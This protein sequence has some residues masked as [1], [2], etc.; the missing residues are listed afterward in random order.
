MNVDQDLATCYH[1][2]AHAVFAIQVSG[3]E[4]RYVDADEL[5]CAA[6]LRGFD[7]YGEKWRIALYHLAGRFSEEKKI[8]GKIRPESWDDFSEE[9]RIEYDEGQRG[10]SHALLET[11]HEMGIPSQEYA[12]VVRDTE[13]E[14]QEMGKI[15]VHVP[16]PTEDY[17]ESFTS[18]IP[19]L[20][21][22]DR[23]IKR[24]VT[25]ALDLQRIQIVGRG[26][27]WFCDSLDV[28]Q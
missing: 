24:G 7:G 15:T 4:V 14:V 9:A 22:R 11:L 26:Y 27:T 19:A 6:R 25:V 20:L 17:I 5:M 3:G 12:V 21:L 28:V 23:R 10:D 8:W 2:A 16:Y 1:E 13:V 18:W